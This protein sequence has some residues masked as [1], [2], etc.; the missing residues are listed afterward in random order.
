[1]RVLSL[2]VASVGWGCAARIGVR[3]SAMGKKI[4]PKASEQMGRL[5]EVERLVKDHTKR[6]TVD[7][8]S[9]A[10]DQRMTIY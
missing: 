4:R 1:M 10:T 3:I 8:T 9:I 5:I 6:L 2:G 7:E